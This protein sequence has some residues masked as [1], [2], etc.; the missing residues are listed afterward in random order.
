MDKSVSPKEAAIWTFV[1]V[2]FAF[3]FYFILVNFGHIVHGVTDFDHLKEISAK[4]Q[5]NFKIWPDDFQASLREM[6]NQMGTQFI[7]GYLVEYS[8]SADNLFVILLIFS[9]FNVEEKHH[10]LILL[11]GVLGAIVLRFLFIFVGGLLINS[12][13]FTLYLF[14][15]FLLISGLRLL[16]VKEDED[17][18]IDTAKHPVVKFIS[19]YFSVYPHNVKSYFFFRK[20]GKFYFTPLFV[21]LLV[22]EF[23]DLIFAVDSVPAIFGIT[24]DPFIVFFSN[25]FAIM[26]LRS[27]FFLLSNLM[28]LFRYLKYGLALILVFIGFKMFADGWLHSIGFNHLWSLFIILGIL[29]SSIIISLLNPKPVEN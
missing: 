18:K 19:R 21:V 26:G 20:K 17:K 16:F 14:G 9:S 4:Y 22:V 7:T 12:F 11:W 10:K 6:Q 15:G 27:L 13:H 2:S 28:P 5:L 1:W 24:K 23:S 25:I 29:S 8:L 3:I